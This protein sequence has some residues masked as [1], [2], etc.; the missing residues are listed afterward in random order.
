MINTEANATMMT[1]DGLNLLPFGNPWTVT[2]DGVTGSVKA[3]YSTVH[4]GKHGPQVT[5]E[6]RDSKN[7]IVDRV[8]V[9]RDPAKGAEADQL[10]WESS[11]KKESGRLV[12]RRFTLQWIWTVH[13][14]E[15]TSPMTPGK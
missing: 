11:I 9:Y 2:E 14:T 8:I 1:R 10:I 3:H 5:Y 7:K 6:T 4:S 13:D 15:R 12:F